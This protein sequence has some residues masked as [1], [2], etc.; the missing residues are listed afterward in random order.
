MDSV[1]TRL[2]TASLALILC[3]ASPLLGQHSADSLWKIKG[4]YMFLAAP[5]VAGYTIE[6]IDVSEHPTVFMV[7]Q[8]TAD[9]A[10]GHSPKCLA[11]RLSTDT[12]AFRCPDTPIGS[13]TVNGHFTK[14]SVP[15][16]VIRL[17]VA[18]GGHVV[19]DRVFTL[20]PRSGDD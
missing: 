16:L 3:G 8:D 6:Q 19:F 15:L 1:H 18:R 17:K 7:N 20:D 9:V 13:V 2:V 4:T 5:E 10:P 12:L 14:G 11:E